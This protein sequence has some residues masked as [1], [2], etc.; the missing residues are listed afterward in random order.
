MLKL[1]SNEID[2]ISNFYQWFVGFS[3][4]ESNFS[5]VPKLN[6]KGHVINRFGF[7]FVIRLHIDDKSAL[8]KIQACLGIGKVSVYDNECKFSI[9]R[10]EDI[11]F[12]FTIFDIYKLNT[13]KYLDYLDFKKAFYLYKS[14]NDL[15]S[16]K[17]IYNILNLKNNM[18]TKRTKFDLP[19]NH[20]K[21][22]PYWLL[23]L[24][25]GEGSFQLWRKDFIPVFS[26]VLS[27]TQKPVL[28]KIKEYIINDLEFDE[29]SVFKLHNSSNIAINDQKARNNSKSSVLLIIKDV[30]ILYN[31]FVPFLAD[32]IF[33]TK[34][35]LDFLDFRLI[36]KLIY[37]GIHKKE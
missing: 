23:G 24:I 10:F 16:D 7:M 20:I 31:Y 13:T 6:K 22:T 2:N 11:E 4:A 5:I 15:V 14:R 33:L 28:I 27:Y 21:I 32:K 35:G 30:R 19:F 1:Y 9:S 12:L 34:K 36:C 25:E 26:I 3:D 17:L 18:N 29:N 8:T 37:F